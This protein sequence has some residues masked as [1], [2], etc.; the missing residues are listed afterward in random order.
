MKNRLQ[1]KKYLHE[2]LKYLIRF[3]KKKEEKIFYNYRIFLNHCSTEL[4]KN[5]K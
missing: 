1:K 5:Y 2:I 3:L 4:V